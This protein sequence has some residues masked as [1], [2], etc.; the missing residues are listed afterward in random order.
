MMYTRD[1]HTPYE[2]AEAY[3]KGMQETLPGQAVMD[4]TKEFTKWERT[5]NT[6][7]RLLRHYEESFYLGVYYVYDLPIMQKN[8]FRLTKTALHWLCFSS[9][10]N[11]EMFNC[12]MGLTATLFYKDHSSLEQISFKWL[13][14]QG[15]V[16]LVD[17]LYFYKIYQ[18]TKIKGND[19]DT[20]FDHMTPEQYYRFDEQI[21]NKI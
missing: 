19:R 3:H 8:K 18:T 12:L 17:P 9:N 2:V 20:V 13:A 21:K 4:L 14:E 10:G 16:H 7:A 11:V 6:D 5:E 15:L 1:N